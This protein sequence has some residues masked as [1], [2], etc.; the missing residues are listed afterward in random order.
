MI[1]RRAPAARRNKNGH[2]QSLVLS[3]LALGSALQLLTLPAV[4]ALSD[5]IGRRPTIFAGAI[6]TIAPAFPLFWMISSGSGG[7]LT[8][9]LL[10]GRAV[11]QPL[12]YAPWPAVMAESFGTGSRYTGASLGY[13][14]SSL[15]GGGFA[16]LVAS[17][18]LVA[19]HGEAAYVALFVA[20]CSV[21]TAIAVR[22][23][24]ETRNADRTGGTSAT[25]TAPASLH[26]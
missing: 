23:I 11:L 2:S 15:L 19:G 5:H 4:A 9:A 3:G 16:P 6:A 10:L 20:A 12:T 7:W 24:R 18:L 1:S 25:A 8:V 26:D 13:Q 14:L 22:L 21:A 17:S